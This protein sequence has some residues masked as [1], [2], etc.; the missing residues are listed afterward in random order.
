MFVPPSFRLTC[1]NNSA[2]E[3]KMPDYVPPT[4]WK[5]SN[6]TMLSFMST[7]AD[8]RSVFHCLD[9]VDFFDP[10]MNEWELFCQS[11]REFGCRINEDGYV[12]K[13]WIEEC[14]ECA[15][16]C[17]NV[18]FPGIL[19]IH[20]EEFCRGDPSFAEVKANKRDQPTKTTFRNQCTMRVCMDF[21]T[22][23]RRNGQEWN[24]INLKMF[25]NGKIQMTGCQSFEQARECVQFLINKL[26]IKAPMMRIK[27]D[28]MTAIRCYRYTFCV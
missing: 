27:R 11:R 14:A 25:Q 22:D 4:P 18:F 8:L 16:Q 20:F 2:I 10:T 3:V 7:P 13:E 12:A 15:C 23:P 6:M 26:M 19:D 9:A 28:C 21:S 17:L 5:I 24:I 1:P